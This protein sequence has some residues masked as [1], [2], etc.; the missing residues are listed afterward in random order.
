M[1]ADEKYF[2]VDGHPTQEYVRR[3]VGEEF[4]PL[5]TR[6][7]V[8]HPEYVVVWACIS[9]QGQGDIVFLD[10][11]LD[12]DT[13]GKLMRDYLPLAADKAFSFGSGAW[14][15]LHDNPN[16]HRGAAATKA[17]HD[18]GAT[19]L[20][21]PP[22][23]PDLNVIENMWAYLVKKVDEHRSSNRQELARW[24]QQEWDDLP[25]EYFSNLFASYARRCQAV[26]DADGSHTKY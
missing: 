20:E 13:Y 19:V 6:H 21:F 14:Y 3:P 1:C 22:Y 10:G 16:V 26:I 4:N 23:S 2:Y 18:A 12:G 5:Y 9:A 11:P 17:L 7:K 24:V 8:A 25:K 15:Y